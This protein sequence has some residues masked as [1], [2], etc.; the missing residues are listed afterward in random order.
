MAAATSLN[1]QVYR[2]GIN[3]L[4]I[5]EKSLPE[6][7][8]QRPQALFVGSSGWFEDNPRQILDFALKTRL[9]TLYVRREYVEMGGIMSYGI[10]YREMYR[11]AASYIVRILKGQNPAELPVIQP[12]K[13]QLVINLKSAKALGLTITSP[14][15]IRADE[16]IE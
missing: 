4:T 16:V 15:L 11:N 6:L 2:L 3:N 9:P 8:E 7:M 13:V 1:V 14:L 5:L 10:D 12:T